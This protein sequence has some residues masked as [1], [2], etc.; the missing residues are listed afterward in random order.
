MDEQPKATP[1]FDPLDAA[2]TPSPIPNS[3]VPL[4]G[5]VFDVPKQKPVQVIQQFDDPFSNPAINQKV[6][7]ARMPEP[8]DS[9][10]RLA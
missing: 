7:E 10:Q 2:F 1:I 8:V 3:S 6:E 4:G 9:T 5:I